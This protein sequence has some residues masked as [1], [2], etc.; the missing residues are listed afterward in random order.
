MNFKVKVT[1]KKIKNIIIK[2]NPNA[3]VEISAPKYISQ[4]YLDMII[5][6]KEEWIMK[7]INSINQYYS[8]K[9]SI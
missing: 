7:K 9:K 5:S 6:Q 4:K 8:T 1:R 3:E 2:I